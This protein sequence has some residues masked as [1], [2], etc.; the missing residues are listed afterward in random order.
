M[1]QQLPALGV[2]F[3]R[4]PS[5]LLS[6][7]VL[8]TLCA[9]ALIQLTGHLPIRLPR[10]SPARPLPMLPTSIEGVEPFRDGVIKFIDDNF[11]LRAE[12]VRLNVLIHPSIGVSSV[13]SLMVGKDGWFFLK[14]HN[15]ILDQFRGLSRLTDD[16]LDAW[17]DTMELYNAGW[18]NKASPSSLSL[19]RTNRRSIPNTCRC[20]PTASGRKRSRSLSRR[21]H[22]RH[23]KLAF[24]DPRRDLW[25]ARRQ[26]SLLFIINMKITGVPLVH[27]LDTP[28]R[29][30]R[31]REPFR[32]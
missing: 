5:L 1:K 17:I 2:W 8:G 31:S 6:F 3:G 13:P 29:C 24:V 16:E 30:D 12:M 11:G 26:S 14:T 18:K 9:P 20:T 19:R 23:S 15:D 4:I 7:L 27:L 25:A 32:R 28:Q 21:L 22:E 10:Q